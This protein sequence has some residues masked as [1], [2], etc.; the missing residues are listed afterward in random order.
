[1][2]LKGRIGTREEASTA[3]PVVQKSAGGWLE[4][5]FLLEPKSNDVC[6]VARVQPTITEIPLRA[7][8]YSP[9][10]ETLEK[11]LS[12]LGYFLGNP[13]W[14][15]TEDTRNAVRNYQWSRGLPAT[16]IADRETLNTLYLEQAVSR[17]AGC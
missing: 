6:F 10:V 4:G 11:A 12:D 14:Y 15:F 1:G 13:E 9:R 2:Q 3:L 7:G 16:G 17:G 8:D 5:T